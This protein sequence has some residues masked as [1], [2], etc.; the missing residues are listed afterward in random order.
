MTNVSLDSFKLPKVEAWLGYSHLQ[1]DL[2]SSFKD[3]FAT[4]H[5]KVSKFPDNV[6]SGL[7]HK[8]WALTL[9][10]DHTGAKQTEANYLEL[11]LDL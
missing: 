6:I 11:V 4:W 3:A 8:E 7:L 2:L 9:I 5:I 1:K 10:S